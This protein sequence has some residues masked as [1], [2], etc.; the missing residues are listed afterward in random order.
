MS[1]PSTGDDDLRRILRRA[2]ATGVINEDQADRIV[3]LAGPTLAAAVVASQANPAARAA[4][5]MFA[6]VLGY[7]GGAV[8]AVTAIVLG[9]ELWDSLAVAVRVLVLVAVSAAA[10]GAGAGL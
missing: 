6:E 5:T 3:A 1:E 8:T 7:L 9:N 2:V 10:V 4:A